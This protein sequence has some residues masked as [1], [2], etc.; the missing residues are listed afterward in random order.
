V[1]GDGG[2]RKGLSEVRR[3]GPEREGRP[4][5]D[6]VGDDA[7]FVWCDEVSK[8]LEGCRWRF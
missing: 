3:V 7:R 4:V 6:G 2:G 5:G 1:E 8:K